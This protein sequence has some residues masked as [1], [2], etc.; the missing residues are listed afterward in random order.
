MNGT[1]SGPSAMEGFD[2]SSVKSSTSTIKAL[3]V[4]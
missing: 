3:L 1:R 2:V 4:A